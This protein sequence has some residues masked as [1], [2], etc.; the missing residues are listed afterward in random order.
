MS[1]QAYLKTIKEKTGNGPAEFRALAEQKGFTSSGKLT[2][3]T[4]AGDITNWLKEDFELGQGHGMAIYALLKG[5][6][7]ENSK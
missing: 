7:D 1:F 4:K 6:K 2:P 5:I 3:T